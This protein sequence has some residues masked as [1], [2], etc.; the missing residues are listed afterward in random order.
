MN[1]NETNHVPV[2]KIEPAENT[3]KVNSIRSVEIYIANWAEEVGEASKLEYF[4]SDI[5]K[6]AVEKIAVVTKG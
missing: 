1:V 5:E 2:E 4:A 6:C 3:E